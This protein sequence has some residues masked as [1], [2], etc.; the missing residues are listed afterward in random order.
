MSIIKWHVLRYEPTLDFILLWTSVSTLARAKS[1]KSSVVSCYPHSPESH[2]LRLI[3]T[4]IASRVSCDAKNADG[5]EIKLRYGSA[6]PFKF[7]MSF[8]LFCFSLQGKMRTN[9]QWKKTD[10]EMQTPPPHK[11]CSLQQIFVVILPKSAFCSTLHWAAKAPVSFKNLKVLEVN[12]YKKFFFLK[13]RKNNVVKFVNHSFL[14][15]ISWR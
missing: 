1:V 9:K 5:F 11:D 10:S 13:S 15:V 4:D 7:S 12:K 14:F 6:R 8:Q 2:Q 3:V